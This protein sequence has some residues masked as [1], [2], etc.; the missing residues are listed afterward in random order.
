CQ[1][2]WPDNPGVV[3][4]ARRRGDRMKRRSFISLLGGAAAWPLAARAQQPRKT[5]TVGLLGATTPAT[6]GQWIAAFAQRLHELGCHEGR[7]VA[8]EYRFEE[9]RNE[10]M[11]EIVAE[12]VRARADVIV[13]QAT[14]A[15]LTAKNATAAI[16]I[17]FVL[18]GD[19][20]G[21]GLVASLARPGG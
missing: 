9:G 12:F 7:P 20:V 3:S 13:A 17:V 15:A 16:P 14:Q 21:S 8:M 6:A 11:A 1:G 5:P 2:A 19:P 10:G 4:T 18:P